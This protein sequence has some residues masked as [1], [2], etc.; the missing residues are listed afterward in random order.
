MSR[1]YA[2]EAIQ[3]KKR[4]EQ[5]GDTEELFALCDAVSAVEDVKVLQRL[6]TAGIIASYPLPE[7]SRGAITG[8]I[9]KLTPA[10]QG[11]LGVTCPEVERELPDYEAEA[12]AGLPL[13]ETCGGVR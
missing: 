4:Y 11:A 13:I 9:F 5:T 1:K 8:Q 6:K 10:V 3:A 12:V 7:Q 2:A